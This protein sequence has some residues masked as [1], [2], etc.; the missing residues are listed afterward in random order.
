MVTAFLLWTALQL[1]EEQEH[2]VMLANAVPYFAD[3][4]KWSAFKMFNKVLKTCDLASQ[5]E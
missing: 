5:V 1:P 3:G 2:V 4:V